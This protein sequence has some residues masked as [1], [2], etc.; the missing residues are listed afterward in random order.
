VSGGFKLRAV[1]ADGTTFSSGQMT[2]DYTGTGH[3]WKRV[4]IA[5]PAGVT[6]AD[7]DHFVFDAYDNDGIYLT[8]IGD[9][10]IPEPDGESGA[11]I[12]FVRQGTKPL[13]FYV[14]DGSS[15]CTSGTNS[16]GP[17]GTPYNCVGGQVTV[18]K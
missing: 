15:G 14:D 12:D 16:A 17:G 10:F 5:L 18:A 8:A 11:T 3:D 2:A 1:K 6:A 13:A 9:A 7:I 4:A